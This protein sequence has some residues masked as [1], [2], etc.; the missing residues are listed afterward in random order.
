LQ[1][2]SLLS[3]PTREAQQLLYNLAVSRE[4]KMLVHAKTYLI[5]LIAAIPIIVKI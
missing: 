1:M 5:V 4:V 3:E 2:D